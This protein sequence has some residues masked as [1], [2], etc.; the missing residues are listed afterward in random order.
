MMEEKRG[1]SLSGFTPPQAAD[2]REKAPTKSPAH[3]SPLN[4]K[5]CAI[6]AERQFAGVSRRIVSAVSAGHVMMT[7][8][9]RVQSR[10]LCFRRQSEEIITTQSRG[11]FNEEKLG[12]GRQ[13]SAQGSQA[14]S[15]AWWLK[16]SNMATERS[17]DG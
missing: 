1:F 6:C 3:V 2:T 14:A 15:F 4:M 10:A 8:F 13:R 7:D 5:N 11:T 16:L 9:T 12:L 17:L